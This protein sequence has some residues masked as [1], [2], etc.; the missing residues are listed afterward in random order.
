MT[1]EVCG[2]AMKRSPGDGCNVSLFPGES[3]HVAYLRDDKNISDENKV[4][5]KTTTDS[6]LSYGKPDTFK[7][8][9]K[10]EAHQVVVLI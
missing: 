9:K 2:Y 3:V 6:A 1:G 5:F 7:K 4:T 10:K 8:K